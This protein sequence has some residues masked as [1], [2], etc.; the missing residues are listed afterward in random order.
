[1]III[2]RILFANAV[3]LFWNSYMAYLV[4]LEPEIKTQEQLDEY[5]EDFMGNLPATD[6]LIKE[7]HAYTMI[8]PSEYWGAGSYSKWMRVGWALKNTDP[9]R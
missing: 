7:A 2:F 3:A 5:I 8:L 1:V 4:T 9:R 6:Y